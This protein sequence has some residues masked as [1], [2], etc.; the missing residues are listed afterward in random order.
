[1]TSSPFAT[2]SSSIAVTDPATGAVVKEFTPHTP[3]EI[4]QRLRAAHDA[5]R[6]LRDTTYATRASW[7]RQAADLLEA[8]R[9]EM[10]RTV[11]IEMGKTIRQARDEITKSARTMRYY[12]DHAEEFLAD[13]PLDR[14]ETVGAR[15]AL[16][17]YQPLGVVLA[18]MPWNYPIWQVVRFAAPALMAGNAG[19]LKHAS[20]VPESALYLD[21]LFTRAGFPAGA[22]STLL[23]GS[24]AVEAVIADSRIAAVTLTGSEGAGRAV[25][26][27]AGRAIKK[28]VLELGGSDPFVV[29]PSADIDQAAT[30]AVAARMN[31]NGQ[32][33]IAGKRF[34]VHTDVYDRFARSFAEKVAAL[35]VGNPLDETTDI[36]PIATVSG[37]DE[38]AEQVDDALA[39]GARVLATA[40]IPAEGTGAYYPPTVLEGVGP[41]ARLFQEEAFGPV[42]VLYRA[43]SEEEAVAIANNTPFGLSSSVWTGDTEQADRVVNALQAGAVFVNGMSISHPELPFGGVRNSGYGRE[44]GAAGIRE[45]CNMKTVWVG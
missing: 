22:F 4:E 38:L 23:T 7:M 28:T 35:K 10:A 16:T 29:F 31:N 26:A 43:D 37:R 19:V 24:G 5:D 30:T 39:H 44:L 36:G 42:A 12:A 33:C 15:R 1:M 18:V 11:V 34:I 6:T 27:A 40:G 17:R 14:P 20:N 25:G 13:A 41:E 3:Q 8:D 2:A 21:T 32:S 45:F 9:D